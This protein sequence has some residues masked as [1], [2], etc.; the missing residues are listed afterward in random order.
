MAHT[1]RRFGFELSDDRRA[2]SR[3]RRFRQRKAPSPRRV[4]NSAPK[5]PA[6]TDGIACNAGPIRPRRFAGALQIL[7]CGGSLITPIFA[8]THGAWCDHGVGRVAHTRRRFG[9]ELSDDRRAHSRPRRFRQRKAPSPRRVGNS[10]PK[11]PANTDGI[12][13]NAGPI[14]PRRFAGALQILE[15]GGSLITPIFARTHGAW[16]DHGVGRVAH[17]RRRF[18]FELSDDRRAHSR[19]RRFRQRKAPSP[20]RVGNSAPKPPANTDGITCNAGPIKPRRFAG[21]LQIPSIAPRSGHRAPSS[22]DRG[23]WSPGPGS[24][25][26]GSSA[27]PRLDGVWGI[28]ASLHRNP[29]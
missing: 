19:P 10:A 9:F 5:S 16:C 2:H 15:C 12:A 23:A 17:T 6:N 27:G 22:L 1:R 14:R 4:G 20:R 24:N 3:P 18:G 26:V 25:P 13:C 8:R 7:E 28:G 11:S 29:A 21:A